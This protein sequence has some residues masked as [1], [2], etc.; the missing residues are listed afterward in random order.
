MQTRKKTKLRKRRGGAAELRSATKL[1]AVSNIVSK[2][3]VTITHLAKTFYS[4]YH[5]DRMIKKEDS[6]SYSAVG[7]GTQTKTAMPVAFKFFVE[8][9]PAPQITEYA[10][11][12]EQCAKMKYEQLVYQA[13]TR[14]SVNNTVTFV[15]AVRLDYSLAKNN[16]SAETLNAL[17]LVIPSALVSYI[18]YI[19]VTIMERRPMA[20]SF[21]HILSKIALS[22][23]AL[24][25]KS[26]LWQIVF[27]LAVLTQHQIQH[28]D[29]HYGNILVDQKPVES[30]ITYS[31]PT[32]GQ[33][34]KVDVGKYGKV[35]LFDWDFSY[36]AASGHNVSLD[37]YY[38][39]Q[40]GIC[41]SVNPRFDL[42]TILY[43]IESTDV[44]FNEFKQAVRGS[45]PIYENFQ[46]RMCNI[47][48]RIPE[49]PV[50]KMKR[51][52]RYT[53]KA[54]GN[55]SW[56]ACGLKSTVSPH[57]NDT[58]L[59][60]A[61][62]SCKGTGTVYRKKEIKCVPYPLN[63]PHTVLTPLQALAHPYF[64]ALKI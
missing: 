53:I 61:T 39:Q 57:V 4:D 22:T 16:L 14:A 33:K 51:G 43:Y 21:D 11:A 5:V 63:E 15:A 46:G 64:D 37:N 44:A 6:M 24:Q 3:T 12:N 30:S 13:I 9:T 36:S 47:N 2:P 7:F 29:L 50:K 56:P 62:A 35:L 60:S 41:N 31:L 17:Q 40:S 18:K 32:T 27:T 1:M 59:S 10:E 25:L 42:F 52:F 55:T 54:L 8:Y 45:V 48:P 34:Y 26:L 20:D 19:H 49:I 28:N 58:F 38:C 23:N